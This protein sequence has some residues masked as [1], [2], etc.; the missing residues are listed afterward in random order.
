M[1]RNKT[2]T[3]APFPVPHLKLQCACTHC[4]AA[5]LSRDIST[6]SHSSIDLALLLLLDLQQQG[7]VDVRQDATEGNGRADQ[8]VEFLVTTD[9]ELQMTG[10]N[11]LDLEILGSVACQFENFG[12]KILQNSSDIDSSFGSDAHL[13]LCIVLQET[14]DATARE[15][16]R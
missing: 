16:D 14:L 9:S 11:A 4:V 6:T 3:P 1:S 5:I 15:L 2:A 7:A 13:V 8:G 12:G 10:S